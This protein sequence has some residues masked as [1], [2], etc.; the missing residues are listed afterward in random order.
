MDRLSRVLQAAQGMGG[1]ASVPPG[2]VRIA[3]DLPVTPV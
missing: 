1:M 3:W 2:Q